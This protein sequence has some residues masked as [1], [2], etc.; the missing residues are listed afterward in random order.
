MKH[1]AI[2]KKL[3]WFSEFFFI[4]DGIH[5]LKVMKNEKKNIMLFIDYIKFS[6]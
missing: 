4:L 6:P 1:T 5:S 2:K 3:V